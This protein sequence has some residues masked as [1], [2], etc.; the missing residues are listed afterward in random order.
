VLVP[1]SRALEARA[2]EG[3]S[4]ASAWGGATDIAEES[5]EA[6]AAL[7]PRIGRARTHL[8]ASLGTRDAGAVSLAL[9]CRAIHRELLNTEEQEN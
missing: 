3:E 1:F 6:T 4:L 7:L 5:A 8:Q 9:I 2:A